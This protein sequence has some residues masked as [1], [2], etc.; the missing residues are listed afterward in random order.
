MAAR[1]FELMVDSGSPD[2]PE[3]RRFSTYL[4]AVGAFHAL[5]PEWQK[6]AWFRE[7]RPDGSV[8]E[9]HMRDG[10]RA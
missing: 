7:L 3:P 1:L 10:M 2:E 6:F 8:K 5:E 9:V 4:K